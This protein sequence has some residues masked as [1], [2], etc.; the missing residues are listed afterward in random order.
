M[1]ENQQY[2]TSFPKL[3]ALFHQKPWLIWYVKEYES[4]DLESVT[5]S[6]I[7]NG[8]WEDVQ[9]L[10]K[11]I[12]IKAIKIIF[13]QLAEKKRTNLPKEFIQFFTHYFKVHAS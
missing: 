13:K 7:L 10:I 9:L 4:L 2:L 12:G 11:E 1:P 3:L 6:I 8:N 5:E